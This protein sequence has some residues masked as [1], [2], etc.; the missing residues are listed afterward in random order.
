MSKARPYQREA[1][2]HHFLRLASICSKAFEPSTRCSDWDERQS[3]RFGL[4][5]RRRTG[6]GK[7]ERG[8]R[9]QAPHRAA[10]ASSAA[11]AADLWAVEAF[12][13]CGGQGRGLRAPSPSAPSRSWRW[14]CLLFRH[15]LG[16]HEAAQDFGLAVVADGHN[17]SSYASF[18][19]FQSSSPRGAVDLV[20]PF[21]GFRRCAR[22]RRVLV[23]LPPTGSSFSAL[24]FSFSASF[25]SFGG[26]GR[27][28]GTDASELRL[29]L[30]A[31]SAWA[32]VHFQ[33][34]FFPRRTARP[35]QASPS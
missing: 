25:A 29:I 8:Q 4:R 5:R 18:S 17:R 23:R 35:W 3:A 28:S 34:S 13:K 20:E 31:E 26:Q 21:C 24:G 16:P 9:R 10:A 32:S 33:P 27:Q 14:P 2:L 11:I 7:P 22:V 1:G 6:R 12:G 19:G 30:I 15:V